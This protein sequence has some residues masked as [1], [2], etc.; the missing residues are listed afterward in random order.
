MKMRELAKIIDTLHVQHVDISS[1]ITSDREA[2]EA[3]VRMRKELGLEE[4]AVERQIGA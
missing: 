4:E 2:D 1:F 3:F